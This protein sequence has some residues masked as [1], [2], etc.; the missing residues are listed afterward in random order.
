MLGPAC[1]EDAECFGCGKSF[2]VQLNPCS[3]H[4]GGGGSG[5]VKSGFISVACKCGG[6]SLDVPFRNEGI[7]VSVHSAVTH[8]WLRCFLEGRNLLLVESVK[9]QSGY[10]WTG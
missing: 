8:H 6:L 2:A 3:L 10:G 7:G 9:E 5:G 4:R 1:W